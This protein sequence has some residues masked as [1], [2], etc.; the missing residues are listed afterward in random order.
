MSTG[1]RKTLNYSERHRVAHLRLLAPAEEGPTIYGDR[2][3]KKVYCEF[4]ILFYYCG[5]C[6][7]CT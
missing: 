2:K 1:P 5:N 4:Y 7:S 6:S 3:K